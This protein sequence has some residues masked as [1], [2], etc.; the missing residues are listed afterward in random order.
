M[1][2]GRIP[3]DESD[4]P[5]HAATLSPTKEVQMHRAIALIPVVVTLS[6]AMA[7]S[8]WK[9]AHWG[10]TPEQVAQASGGAVK[11][12]PAAQRKKHAA[13]WSSETAA[14]GTYVDG[15]LHLALSFSFD[16][17]RG[18]LSCIVFEAAENSPDDLLKQ[19]FINLNGRP[20]TADDHK[21]L[22][23][24]TFSWSTGKDQ[25]GLTLMTDGGSFATQCLP[26]TNPPV[27]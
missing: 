19:M 20:Q 1:V 23:M 24:Q 15:A 8:D 25:I 16:S 7:W 6:P 2:G 17:K 9:Y 26:G 5:D 18:G 13:P 3:L 10:A 21:D 22:G 14:K 4:R 12:L 11:V 27:E